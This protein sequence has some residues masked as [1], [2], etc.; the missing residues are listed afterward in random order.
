[1]NYIIIN[2]KEYP[3][4]VQTRPSDASWGGRESKAITL[5]A[6]YEEAMTLFCNDLLWMYG[7][8]YEDEN[9]ETVR[10]VTDMSSYALAG[11][12]TDNRDGTV[13]AKMGK[14]RDE[15]LMETVLGGVPAS[16]AG[17]LEIRAVMETAAQS[18][19]DASALVVKPM[20]PAW[21]ELV[22]SGYTAEKAGYKFGYKGLL[23]KTVSPNTAF[24]SH[25]VPG[26]GTES[27]Y[28]R[29]DE[30][31]VGSADDPIPYEGNMVLENGKYYTQTGV[32]Y[33]CTRDTVN[34]VHNALADLVGI[35]VEVAA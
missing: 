15:E 35:Y 10:T 31:H 5:E 18:L 21:E 7:S 33:L 8:T 17:A 4:V 29:I 9:G 16:H 26:E 1:M 3:A 14:Y 30:N 34:P 20:Y 25:W 13:T 27:L 24:A 12:V 23:Y 32:K 22:D 19:D 2:S 28:V 11:P 6:T